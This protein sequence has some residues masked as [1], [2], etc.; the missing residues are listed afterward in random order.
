MCFA[1]DYRADTMLFWT[2]AFCLFYAANGFQTFID[3]TRQKLDGLYVFMI[4]FGAA[5][6][7]LSVAGLRFV[8]FIHNLWLF[9]WASILYIPFAALAKRLGND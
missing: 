6:L 5:L 1:I 2:A 4:F 3:F 9:M 8:S 7:I